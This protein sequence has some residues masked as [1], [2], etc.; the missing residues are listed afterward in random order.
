MDKLIANIADS[1]VS[2]NC[3]LSAFYKQ[4]VLGEIS[5]F[6]YEQLASHIIAINDAK[7]IETLG[8]DNP[9]F[10]SHIIPSLV[11]HLNESYTK[12]YL[13]DMSESFREG[14]VQYLK[15][16]MDEILS[17]RLSVLNFNECEY[18][19]SDR[20]HIIHDDNQRLSI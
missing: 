13:F 1:I 11:K 14:I 17:E 20:E 18:F 4:Y 19:V 2:A 3:S 12:E 9:F 5:D 10:L 16:Y 8:P 6:E 15:P 7:A